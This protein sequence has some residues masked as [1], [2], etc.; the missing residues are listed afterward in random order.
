MPPPHGK[1]AAMKALAAVRLSSMG[2]TS[3]CSIACILGVGDSDPNR[4][5]DEARDL[6]EPST[7]AEQVVI[8]LDEMWHHLKKRFAES[9]IGEEMVPGRGAPHLARGGASPW[10]SHMEH[11]PPLVI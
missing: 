6:P 1:P 11:Q 10:E 2:N 3:F 8:T 7:G 5:R 9:G 4:D